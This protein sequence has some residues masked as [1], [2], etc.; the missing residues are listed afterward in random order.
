MKYKLELI[1]LH[2]KLIVAQRC[3]GR[4][5]HTD[6]LAGPKQSHNHGRNDRSGNDRICTTVVMNAMIRS[7]NL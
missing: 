5:V 6:S 2:R 1:F 4:V 7:K 3:G